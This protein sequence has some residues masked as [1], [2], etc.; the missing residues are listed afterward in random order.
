[1]GN[2]LYFWANLL[3]NGTIFSNLKLSVMKNFLT[4]IAV[5]CFSI[6]YS[7]GAK[8][9]KI[10]YFDMDVVLKSVPE[11]AEANNQLEL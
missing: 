1:M 6:V 11:F 3:K 10:G 2:P 4:F 8:G 5:V 7:Q 9:P